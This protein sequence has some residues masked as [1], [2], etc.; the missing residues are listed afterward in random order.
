ME[1]GILS[2]GDHLPDPGDGKRVSQAE[3]HRSI[4]EMGVRAEELGF[5]MIAL[6]EHHFNDYIVASPQ[7]LLAAIAERTE[8]IRLAP[9]V[10]LLPMT[11]PVRV[12]EDYAT[13]DLLSGGRM[14]LMVGRG[15]SPDHYR[16]FG[17]DPAEDRAN[18][19][20]KLL[21]L[22]ELWSAAKQPV[23]W[24]GR[25]RAPL[26]GLTV[27]PRPLQASP[28]IW[29]GSGLSED[30]VR[31]T[32]ERGRPLFL[33]SILRR[34]E[35]Y[36]DLVALYREIME[37]SGNGDRAFVGACSHLHVGP[38]SGAAREKWRPHLLQY[39]TW[40][41]GIRGVDAEVDFDRVVDG[42]AVCGSPAEVTE[43]LLRI[44]ELLN[45]DVHLSVFDIGGLPHDD[46]LRSMEL[47]SAEV[48][49]KV[50]G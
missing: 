24:T 1:L 11:D 50:S 25:F 6:G 28:R 4:V 33:P 19:D 10:V 8:R 37:S 39:A 47:F 7:L 23:T 3:R 49:P 15:I 46:V 29:M 12:A 13:L 30:S 32:A 16:A 34:P 31:R 38:T 14:E 40:V 43:R 27:Q 42:P 17:F 18:L 5:A 22:D 2:L 26:D 21:L 45:P 36:A 48:M 44:K 35:S 20:E 41:N 9:A